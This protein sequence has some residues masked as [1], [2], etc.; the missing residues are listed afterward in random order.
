MRDETRVFWRYAYASYS[1]K[2]SFEQTHISHSHGNLRCESRKEF[3]ALGLR[4]RVRKYF[5][6][7]ERDGEAIRSGRQVTRLIRD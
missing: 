4:S 7:V 6:M 5:G 2:N 3:S 1:R